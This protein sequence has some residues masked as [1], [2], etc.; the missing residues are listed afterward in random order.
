[1]SEHPLVYQV[2]RFLDEEQLIPDGADVVIGLSGGPDSTCLAHVL[3]VVNVRGKRGWVLTAAHLDHGLR[4]ESADEARK[5][6]EFAESLGIDFVGG[7]LDGELHDP[8]EEQLR[9]A[10]YRRA[11]QARRTAPMWDGCKAR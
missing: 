9:D 7:T 10:R 6:Q 2:E 1:M 8:S 11:P 4:P 5:A 3:S